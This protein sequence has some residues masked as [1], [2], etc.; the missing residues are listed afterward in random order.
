MILSVVL[1]YGA[2]TQGGDF[3]KASK[4]RF[5]GWSRVW[6]LLMVLVMVLA[7]SGCSEILDPPDTDTVVE[8][9]DG[10]VSLRI[11]QDAVPEGTV[12]NIEDVTDTA[13]GG[14]L[15]PVYSITPEGLM[16]NS[17]VTLSFSYDTD[18]VPPEVDEDL[19]SIVRLVD[20]G[21]LCLTTDHDRHARTLTTSLSRSFRQK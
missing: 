10:K 7:F 15:G 20:V 18:D 12:I 2:Y 11:P 8:S 21:W 3:M 5:V 17:P 1:V 9:E 6:K 4:S 13:P 16:F 19:L 14:A